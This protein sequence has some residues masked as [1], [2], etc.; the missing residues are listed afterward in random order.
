MK[1]KTII[2]LLTFTTLLTG[3]ASLTQ[4]PYIAPKNH[5][6]INM[7]KINDTTYEVTAAITPLYATNRTLTWNVEWA[8]D[9]AST[10]DDNNFKV[11]KTATDFVG[12]AVSTNTLVATLTLKTAFASQ[13]NVVAA[14]TENPTVKATVKID[15]EKRL[16]QNYNNGYKLV[17][18]VSTNF[19]N[20]F[21]YSDGIGSV[22][23]SKV[24][25]YEYSDKLFWYGG[26]Q[27]TPVE[28]TDTITATRGDNSKNLLNGIGL[29]L[30]GTSLANF[31]FKTKTYIFDAPYVGQSALDDLAYAAT[32]GTTS[33]AVTYRAKGANVNIGV[34]V[35]VDGVQKNTGHSPT[36]WT[37]VPIDFTGYTVA[38]TSISLTETT[39]I[40]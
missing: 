2:T 29:N 10:T 8:P 18:A 36:Q 6:E 26:S 15:Y 25:T 1:R 34:K 30:V 37:M 32:I 7:A 28:W 19:V 24:V 38:A 21:T 5:F 39:I 27:T 33:Q 17:P 16:Q 35:F 31:D 12:L 13:I 11:G 22:N 14:V 20:P 3:C 9:A 23:H 40:F 4:A